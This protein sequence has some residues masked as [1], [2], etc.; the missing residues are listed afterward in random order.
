MSESVPRW[1]LVRK[2]V[3]GNWDLGYICHGYELD[4]T[5]LMIVDSRKIVMTKVFGKHAPIV[6]AEPEYRLS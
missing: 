3:A 6:S 4:E 5:T 2:G 1:H